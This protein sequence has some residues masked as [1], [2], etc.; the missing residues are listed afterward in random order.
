MEMTVNSEIISMLLLLQKTEQCYT[1]YNRNT[2]NS[3]FDFFLYLNSI[4]LKSAK[5]KIAP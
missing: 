5:V 4:F 3:N 2:L 1:C